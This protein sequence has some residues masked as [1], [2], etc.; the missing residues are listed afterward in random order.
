MVT[1][2]DRFLLRLCVV[3]G[4]VAA[5][6]IGFGS[7]LV[8]RWRA[9]ESIVVGVLVVSVLLFISTFCILGIKTVGRAAGKHTFGM[10]AL[11]TL[12]RVAL[13]VLLPCALITLALIMWAILTHQP[14]FR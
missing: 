3:S 10:Q 11:Y 13:F 1:R 8:E 4:G 7:L 5:M 6:A 2:S 9:P 12:L 14:A